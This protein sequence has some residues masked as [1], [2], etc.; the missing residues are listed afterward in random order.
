MKV[1]LCVLGAF[2]GDDVQRG[3]VNE[4]YSNNY[5]AIIDK[6]D[7]RGKMH[8]DAQVR[9]HTDRQIDR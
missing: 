3:D 4:W 1:A 5:E 8:A 9:R 6:C 7:L 2:R